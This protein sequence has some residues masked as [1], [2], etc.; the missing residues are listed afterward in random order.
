VR[1]VRSF[2]LTAAM[3]IEASAATGLACI[4]EIELPTY[5]YVARRSAGGTVKAIV[6]IGNH[7]HAASIDIPNA[8]KDLAEEVRTTLELGT[9]YSDSCR[10]ER[11]EIV[12]TF[13]LQGEPAEYPRTW[14]KFEPPNHFTITSEPR[15]VF[16]LYYPVPGKKD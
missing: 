8:D 4:K 15:K 9:T 12:F 2:V 13:I 16:R 5:S 3:A 10:G 11:V 1:M 6:A 7:G 14:I